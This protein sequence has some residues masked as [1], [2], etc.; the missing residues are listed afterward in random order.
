MFPCRNDAAA[1]QCL[2][3]VRLLPILLFLSSSLRILPPLSV[4]VAPRSRVPSLRCLTGGERRP[5]SQSHSS[6]REREEPSPILGSQ[7][8]LAIPGKSTKS[9]F[10]LTGIDLDTYLDTPSSL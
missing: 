1:P 10:L 7:P 9:Y 2:L 6:E 5:L 4:H 8:G 3:R